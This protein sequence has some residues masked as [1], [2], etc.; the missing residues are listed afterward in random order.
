VATAAAPTHAQQIN[1]STASALPFTVTTTDG[2][3]FEQGFVFIGSITYTVDVINNNNTLKSS[4]VQI[5]CSGTCPRSGTLPLA[6]LQWNRA[7]QPGVWNTLTTAY[8]SIEQKNIQRNVLNDPWGNT[9]NFRYVLSWTGTP[10]TAVTQYRIRFR[11][12]IAN[13]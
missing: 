6:G 8:A 10:P 12:V 4:T 7:D 3:H 1:L 2:G 9:L 11:L 5:Q 13:P